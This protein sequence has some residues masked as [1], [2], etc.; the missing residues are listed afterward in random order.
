MKLAAKRIAQTLDAE[1]V[2]DN[3]RPLDDAALAAIRKQVQAAA[4]A[5]EGVPH[6]ARKPARAGA[7]RRAAT[8]GGARTGR[9]SPAGR[10][11][12]APRRCAREI[13]AHDRRYY[14]RGRADGQRRRVRRAVPRAGG[15]RGGSIRRSSPP[16][17]PTQRV[18]G[19]PRGRVRAGRASRADAVDPHGDRHDGRRRQRVRRAHPPRPRA[20]R[21]RAAG[22]LHG[23]AQVRR[24]G[25]QPALRARRARPWRRRAATARPAR[26]S[27]P[28]C[29]RSRAIPARLRGKAPPRARSARRDLHDARAIS[30]GSTRGRR[31]RARRLFVNPRNT[32]AG[33]VRQL[34]PAMTAQRP[35]RFLRL[36][37]R[38]DRRLDA[39]AVRRARC[40]T[41]WRRSACRST[42]TA[43]SRT[44]RPTSPRFYEEVARAAR[45]SAVRD[46]RRRL[47]G[48]QPGAAASARVSSRA[49]RAGPSRTS[50]RPRRCRR[51]LLAID[52]QVGRTGAITPVARLEPVFVGGTTV[53]NATLHNEDEIRRR[54]RA[55]RRHRHRAARGRRDPAGRARR[56]RRSGRADARE[57]AMPDALPGVRLGGR[58]PARTRSIARCTGGLVC[59]AQRKQALLHFA[60]P[61]RARHRGPGRQARRP[62]GRRGPRPHAGRPLQARRSRSSRRSSGWR[63]RAPPTCSPRSRRARTR[64]SRASSSRS[65]SAT[66][67]R[68]PRKDLA[69]HFGSLDALLSAER[70][71]PAAR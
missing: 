37:H 38:R 51:R 56:A 49:S 70:S 44:A 17:S 3:R 29:A 30:R 32:A 60:E 35:L 63:T 68:R 19:A 67:A 31:R 22:R 64:R 58:A 7:V 25:D 52:V 54:G 42:A 18:G 26:T 53:T 6:R 24:A 21:R 23:R 11:R 27:P 57:F 39:A 50:F 65:A 4:D 13:A 28:T 1:L 40:S 45:R 15:A 47:Q 41:R 34:D 66:S 14:V 20:R 33:A 62:A 12:G 36:R 10:D 2:D 55:H 48:R 61:A 59:P 9:R 43:A 8:C 71:G 16:D 69:R 5:L 46:R